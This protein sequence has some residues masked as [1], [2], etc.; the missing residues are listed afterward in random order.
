VRATLLESN[1]DMALVWTCSRTG[2]VFGKKYIPVRVNRGI[3][4]VELQRL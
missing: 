3:K 4:I 2:S 1:P